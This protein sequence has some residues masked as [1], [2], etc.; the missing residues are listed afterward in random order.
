M[1]KLLL[2][3]VSFVG[4]YGCYT[5]YNITPPNAQAQ[6]VVEGNLIYDPLVPFKNNGDTVKLSLSTTY[7]SATAPP[8][9]TDAAVS[10]TYQIGVL[11]TINGVPTISG[12]NSITDVLV[13]K[14][15]GKYVTSNTLLAPGTS[16]NLNI[17][18]SNGEKYTSNTFIPLRN[19]EFRAL[20]QTDTCR[21]VGT[22]IGV[23]PKGPFIDLQAFD[24]P[25]TKEFDFPDA[26]WI[27][28]FVKRYGDNNSPYSTTLGLNAGQ[29]STWRTFRSNQRL[30]TVFD[31][32]NG[33]NNDEEFA[34]DK[35]A[36]FI[37]PVRFQS[38]MSPVGNGSD[39]PTYF[40]GDSVKVKI[41]AI[42]LPHI[43]FL[44][45]IDRELGNGTGGG[46]SGLFSRPPANVPTN[47]M[48]VD[49]KGK[50]AVG[51]FGG[52]RV[53]EKSIEINK[54]FSFIKNQS[55]PDVAKNLVCK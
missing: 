50:K 9:V 47:I 32:S 35:P 26:Y 2:I 18:L 4:L 25:K 29:Y 5:N 28:T 52:M 49:E 42:T 16:Y 12:S 38:V 1:K 43:S 34:Q 33:A 23:V 22:P 40:P 39:Y 13:H 45:S 41:F 19:C 3:L 37:L 10:I 14:G 54:S 6:L 15:N 7:S 17:T 27:Q 55:S 30:N 36:S 11:T 48:N 20:R 53:L 51:F 8:A 31:I 24:M 46:L 21:I 44:A